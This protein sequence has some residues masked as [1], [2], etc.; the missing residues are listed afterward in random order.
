MRGIRLVKSLL[1]GFVLLFASFGCYG[2]VPFR[3]WRWR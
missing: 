3:R 2:P 1:F